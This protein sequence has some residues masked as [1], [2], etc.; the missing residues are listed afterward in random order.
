ML[1]TDE[2]LAWVSAYMQLTMVMLMNQHMAS[3]NL[4]RSKQRLRKE[5]VI[6]N[7]MG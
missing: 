5:N 2:E 4:H 1:Q 6:K 3:L 7:E